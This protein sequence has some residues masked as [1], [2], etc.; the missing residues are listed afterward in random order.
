[1]PE[2]DALAL[3]TP[4]ERRSG[5]D[6]PGA[7]RPPVHGNGYSSAE[8]SWPDGPGWAPAGGGGTW[9]MVQ[10]PRPALSTSMIVLNTWWL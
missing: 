1:M 5:R 3:E 4:L 8:E 7:G 9:C 2:V 10:R 6:H